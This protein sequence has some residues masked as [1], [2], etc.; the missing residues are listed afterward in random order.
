M[1]AAPF[2]FAILGLAQPSDD[3]SR[4]EPDIRRYEEA[5][6]KKMP[7]KDGVVFVGSSSIV[8][9]KSLASDFPG[10]KVI[11]RGFGGSLLSDSVH[12]AHRIVTPYRPRMVVVFAGTNDLA[13]GRSPERVFADFQAL[14]G[15]VR[16]KLPRTRIA[17]ISVSPT[18]SR[19]AN[20][21]NAIRANR[22]VKEFIQ[23]EENM[24]YIDVYHPMLSPEGLPRPEL[25][26]SD[27]LHLNAQ[28][29]ALWRS[30]VGP[31]LPWR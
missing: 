20:N 17:F 10:N 14:V 12:F 9:W 22:L 11:N 30:V 26:V 5:D 19:W 27:Q 16:E 31:Y 25:F 23:K 29:Y 4:W 7:P 2:L 8:L 21:A 1:L 18:P 28:G 3:P 15:R 24:A 6:R 13:S